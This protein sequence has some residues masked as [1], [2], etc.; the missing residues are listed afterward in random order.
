MVLHVRALREHIP[1]M[2]PQRARRTVWLRSEYLQRACSGTSLSF[3]FD[4]PD[5]HVKI[6][7]S[8]FAF[9]RTRAPS[10]TSKSITATEEIA[11]A[12]MRGEGPTICGGL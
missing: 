2:R 6:S 8:P 5:W 11:D 1:I 10:L 9:R 3:Y 7:G 4:I 12:K